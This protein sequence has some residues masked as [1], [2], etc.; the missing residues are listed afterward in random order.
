MIASRA[1]IVKE[2]TIR[3]SQDRERFYVHGLSHDQ[4]RVY[5][6]GLITIVDKVTR[7]QSWDFGQNLKTRLSLASGLPLRLELGNSILK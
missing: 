3:L 2:S 1:M 4:E 5:D 6:H 7:Q